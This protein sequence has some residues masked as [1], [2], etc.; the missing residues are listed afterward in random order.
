MPEYFL[1]KK[2]LAHTTFVKA[3]GQCTESRN[4]EKRGE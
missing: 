4:Y 3:F 2:L 1:K